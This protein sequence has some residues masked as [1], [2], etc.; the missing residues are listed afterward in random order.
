MK[1][2]RSQALGFLQ[3]TPT[4]EGLRGPQGPPRT[5]VRV[6]EQ[7]ANLTESITEKG[8]NR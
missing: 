2:L 1:R 7:K 5:L 6:G 4:A 3:G 8:K